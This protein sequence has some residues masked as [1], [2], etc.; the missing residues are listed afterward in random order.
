MH[1][2]RRPP[3]NPKL[4]SILRPRAKELGFYQVVGGTERLASLL[5]IRLG[6]HVSVPSVRSYLNGHRT[7][8]APVAIAL[9][10]E[11]DL[12]GEARDRVIELIGEHYKARRLQ[13]A[14]NRVEDD[15]PTEPIPTLD[16]PSAP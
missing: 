5:S 2:D 10:E 3:P 7:P 4:A 12:A 16:P 11:L 15:T 9:C 6:W 8:P 13:Q 14:P 1:S